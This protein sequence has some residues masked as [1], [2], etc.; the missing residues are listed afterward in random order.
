MTRRS[1]TLANEVPTGWIE[2]NTEDAEALGIKDKEMVRAIT[3]RGEIEVPAKV[4]S[5]IMKGVMFIAVPLC[6]VC[7][8][9]ADQQC[10]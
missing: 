3:R 6:R 1:S 7:S 9:Y 2:I 4:T 5:E 8:K 10:T